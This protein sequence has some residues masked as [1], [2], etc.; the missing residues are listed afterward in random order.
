M[1]CLLLA[2]AAALALSGAARAS[3]ITDPNCSNNGCPGGLKLYLDNAVSDKSSFVATVGGHS[4][5]AVTVDTV[6]PVDT[7]AGFATIK[8]ASGSTLVSLTFTPANGGLFGDFDFRGQMLSGFT[9]LATINVNWVGSNGPNDFGTIQFTVDKAN[10]D[11]GAFGIISNDGDTLKSV[12]IAAVT[13]ADFKEVKQIEFS[14][15]DPIDPPTVPEPTSMALLGV[16]L[17]GL[18]VTRYRRKTA[19]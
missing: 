10:Q 19:V 11:F 15:G 2:T 1:K 14:L 7:G 13:P 3:F 17:L 5:P 8:P 4:G 6:G 12:Q 16:G 18:G 9:G